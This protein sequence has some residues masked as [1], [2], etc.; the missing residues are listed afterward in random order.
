MAG[1]LGFQ[2]GLLGFAQPT[3]AGCVKVAAKLSW[4]GFAQPTLAGWA[5]GPDQSG[6]QTKLAGLRSAN[7]GWLGLRPSQKWLHTCVQRVGVSWTLGRGVG[8][9]QGQ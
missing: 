6:C 5:F 7:I 1:H 4:L 3:L 2:S 8:G 9:G